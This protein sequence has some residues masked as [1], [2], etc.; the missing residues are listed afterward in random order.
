MRTRLVAVA[1]AVTSMVAIA[2]LLPLMFLVRDL[3]ADRELSA[4]ERDASAVARL[5]ALVGT[6][7]AGD[8]VGPILT[9]TGD[10]NGRSVSIV[11]PDGSTIGA[12]LDEGEDLSAAASG[13]SF[14]QPVSG[15]SAVYIP[16][17]VPDG[18]PIVVRAIAESDAMRR[19]VTRVW[20]TLVLLALALVLAA[21]AVADRLGRAVVRPI[22]QLSEAAGRLGQGDLDMRVDVAGPPEIQRVGTAFNRLASQIGSLLQSERETA[23]DLSHRL[24]TPLTAARLNV[25]ALDDGDRRERLIAQLDEIDRVVDHVI[26]EMRR[27]DR[28]ARSHETDVAHVVAARMEFWEPLAADE[29]RSLTVDV[30]ATPLRVAVPETDLVAAIDA[31]VGNVFAHT[32]PGV[33]LAV[34]MTATPDHVDVHIDDAGPGFPQDRGVLDRG[35]SGGDSTGLGLDI[36]AR[37]ARATGGELTIGRAPLGGARVTLRLRRLGR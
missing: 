33:A 32:D 26:G 36:A 3:A 10:F 4:A 14:R 31:L 5:L 22:D 23:A 17:L 9:E 37:T 27:P 1:F 28:Q 24:R 18:E 21:V 35:R 12:A 25:D 19:G 16:V 29:R 11:L 7:A 34:S 6:D 8:L 13:A 15:G 2:F 20:V 30:A